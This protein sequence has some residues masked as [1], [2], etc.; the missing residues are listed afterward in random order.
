MHNTESVLGNETHKLLWDFDIQTN[1]LISARRPEFIIINKKERTCRIVDFAVPA[2]YRV[3]LTEC[4]KR[5]KYFDLAW[6]GK[7]TMKHGTVTKELVQ[8]LEDFERMGRVVTV[9]ATALLRSARILRRVLETRGDLLSLKLQ[10][11]TISECR[12][13]KSQGVK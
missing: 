11:K 2:D 1:C 13:E 12:C 3:K 4:E 5:D 8:V 10:L 9:Q 6:E 7:K